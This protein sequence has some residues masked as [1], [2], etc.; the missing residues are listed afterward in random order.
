MDTNGEK[1]WLVTCNECPEQF[2][3]DVNFTARCDYW[4][5]VKGKEVFFCSNQCHQEFNNRK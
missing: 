2:Y 3:I 4:E 1:A 5:E